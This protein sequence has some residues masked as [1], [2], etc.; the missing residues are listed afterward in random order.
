MLKSFPRRLYLAVTDF[1][2]YARIFQEPARNTLLLLL[3][4]ACLVSIILT[5]HYATIFFPAL[6]HFQAWAEE[7]MPSFET[8]EDGLRVDAEQPLVLKYSNDFSLTLVF[9]TTGTYTDPLGLEE[10]AVLL[11][12]DRLFLRSASQTQTYNW[13]EYGDFAFRPEEIETYGFVLRLL[14]FPT[15]YAFLLVYQLLAK[16]VTAL[17]LSFLTYPIGARY[18]IRFT[19][20]NGFTIALYSLVPAITIDLAVKM[21]RVQ[22]DYFDFI[23]LTAA[24]IYTVL[25]AQRCAVAH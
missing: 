4:L 16:S 8:G 23:Y 9:D 13:S 21:T 20:L 7:S 3:Y 22:I 14:Y 11:T 1:D 24:A 12:R 17:L 5:I 15:A 2:F 10:P 25:A 18:G 19:A 6:T